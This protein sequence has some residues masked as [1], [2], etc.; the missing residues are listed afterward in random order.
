MVS[1]N[2]THNID[3]D[4][5]FPLCQMSVMIFKRAVYES[6]R[7]S[8]G[9]RNEPKVNPRKAVNVSL[10]FH[11]IHPFLYYCHVMKP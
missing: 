10:T 7:K 8:N 6:R 4:L 11:I 2:R 9:F 1:M 3:I 5:L